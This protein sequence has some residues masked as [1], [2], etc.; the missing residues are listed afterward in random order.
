MGPSPVGR[1]TGQ[2]QCCQDV[3]GPRDFQRALTWDAWKIGYSRGLRQPPGSRAVYGGMVA[4]VKPGSVLRARVTTRA[5]IWAA[6]RI[7]SAKGG[8][9][10]DCCATHRVSAMKVD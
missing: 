10:A 4:A 5:K 8:G 6:T 9:A 2:R 3:G 1:Q 7:P